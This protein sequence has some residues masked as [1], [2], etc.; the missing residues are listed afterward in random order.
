MDLS[1]VAVNFQYGVR[2]FLS[3][4]DFQTVLAD[5]ITRSFNRSL[6]IRAAALDISMVFDRVWHAGLFH[7]LKSDGVSSQ[8]F[9][10]ILTFLSKR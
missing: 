2:S 1:P 4:A 6:T 10:L 9:G 8:I 5:T 3:T 7:K